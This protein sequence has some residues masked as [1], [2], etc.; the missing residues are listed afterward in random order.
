[1]DSDTEQAILDS[2]PINPLLPPILKSIDN[3]LESQ[4]TTLGKLTISQ[5]VMQKSI[6]F[7]HANSSDLK[8][9]SK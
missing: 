5:N 4:V 3:K 8:D 2:D 6:D 9:W 1:M 7:G